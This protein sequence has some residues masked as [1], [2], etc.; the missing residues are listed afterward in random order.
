VASCRGGSI[1]HGDGTFAGCTEDDEH[2]TAAAAASY[3]ITVT[4]WGIV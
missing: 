2:R 3:G 4:R 1:V